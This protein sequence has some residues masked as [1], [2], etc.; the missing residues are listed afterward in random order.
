MESD[1]DKEF[2][3]GLEKGLMVIEAFTLNNGPLTISDAAKIT[4]HS[5]SSA[6]RSLITLER[7][8]YLETDG[9][10][11]RPAPRLLRLAHAYVA[12]SPLA[13]LVQP[14]L[15][16]LSERT[17]E[18]SSFAVLDGSDAVFVARAAARR[19]LS[20]GLWIGSRL[21]AYCA[22]TGRVL[23]AALPEEEALQRLQRMVRQRLT[24]N[25]ITEI[26]ALMEE[27]ARVRAQGYALNN[28]ELEL[29]VRSIAVP[30]RNAVG[31]TLASV[32][33]ATA[34]SRRTTDN[35]ID[36]LLPELESVRRMLGSL[37]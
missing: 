3:A 15:E 33:L 29:G 31:Q 12:A 2:V 8:G 7:L 37:I 24:P 16:A 10:Q 35:M 26:P 19:S 32:S 18:P 30:I 22:A 28:E 11:F 36:T 27:L 23:L 14:S 25:T 6:R 21:P 5:R 20:S 34:A 17:R 13:K 4:G 9:K 1:S